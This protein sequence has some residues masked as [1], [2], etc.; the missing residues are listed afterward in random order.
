MEQVLDSHNEN[1]TTLPDS[2]YDIRI[3]FIF[4]AINF[5]HSFKISNDLR[6]SI[7]TSL[8]Q[9]LNILSYEMFSIQSFHLSNHK[10]H[11]YI[12]Q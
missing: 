6:Y 7:I 4:I 5:N 1:T 11:L 9:A 2:Y 8:F 10:I 3:L 12:T